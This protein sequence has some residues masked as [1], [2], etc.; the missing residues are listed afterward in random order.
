MAR[1]IAVLNAG[2]S[3]LKFSIFLDDDGELRAAVP[4][5]GGGAVHG[6]RFLVRDQAGATVGETDWPEG[7]R[8]GHDGAIEH[9]FRWADEER[10][11]WAGSGSPR[12]ATASATAG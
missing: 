3:S 8:L 2:S 5:T 1:A 6:P 7:T 10:R 12:W 11:S 9:L 4:R